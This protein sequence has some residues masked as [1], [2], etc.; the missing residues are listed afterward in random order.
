MAKKRKAEAQGQE[1][2][3]GKQAALAQ[4][5]SQSGIAQKAGG[6][7]D[8]SKKESSQKGRQKNCNATQ[9]RGCRSR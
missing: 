3:N 6:E 9:G 2:E 5:E 4:E 8:E 1:G 7:K